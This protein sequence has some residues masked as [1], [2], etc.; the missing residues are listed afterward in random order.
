[1]QNQEQSSLNIYLKQISAIPLISVEEEIELA[2]RIKGDA[3]AR[4]K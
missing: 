1:M 3:R 4:E 2:A